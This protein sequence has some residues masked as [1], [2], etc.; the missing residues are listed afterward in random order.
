MEVKATADGPLYLRLLNH[1]PDVYGAQV[2]YQLSIRALDDTPTPGALV[3]TA[4][5]LTAHDVL[6]TNI[7]SVTQSVYGLFQAHDYDDARIL[8]L[9]S[10]L[11]LDGVDAQ[12]TVDNLR[13]AITSQAR[14]LVGPNRPLTLYLVDHG[15]YDRFYLDKPRGEWVTPAQIDEWLAQLEAAVPG[16]QV[17]VI[18]EACHSG[19]FV[20]WASANQRLQTISKP[21]RVVISSTGARNLAWSSRQGAAFSDPFIS[22]LDAGSSLYASFQ[23]ARWS[24][25][26]DHPTQVPWLDDDGDGRANEPEDGQVAAQR[27][28]ADARTLLEEQWPPFIVKV[29]ATT[30]FVGRQV[31]IHAVVRDDERVARVWAEFYAPS[32]QPPVTGE[33]MVQDMPPI[34]AL[35]AQGNHMYGGVYTGT[36]ESGAYRVV[37][38]AE[39]GDGRRARPVA[40]E[41]HAGWRSYLPLVVDN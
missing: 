10:D 31:T 1:D 15:A 26:V 38:H 21:G 41:V 33:E 30:Q 13:L 18:V 27:S 19:S 8:Y 28:L 20:D 25:Q 14:A 23:Q 37:V 12:A 5:R 32:Y 39:D 7:Y 34:A 17:N 40:I 9:A 6:Q 2:A 4:G 3:L 16:L 11:D 22:S 36:H 24:L 29:S 35:E